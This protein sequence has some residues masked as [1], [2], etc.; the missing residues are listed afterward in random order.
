MNYSSFLIIDNNE[1]VDDILIMS[2]VSLAVGIMCAMCNSCCTRSSPPTSKESDNE[3]GYEDGYEDGT[4][5]RK[6]EREYIH[7]NAKKRLRSDSIESV[8]VKRR[9]RRDIVKRIIESTP[10]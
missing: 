7:R 9:P 4:L 6:R 1:L 10:E 3:D 5:E 2:L 8:I